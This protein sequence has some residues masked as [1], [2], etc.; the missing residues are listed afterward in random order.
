MKHLMTGIAV[1]LIWLAAAGLLL[2]QDMDSV[3]GDFQALQAL[4]SST[5]GTGIKIL[6]SESDLPAPENASY[7]YIYIIND[8]I[9]ALS[10]VR[11]RGIG[12]WVNKGGIWKDKTGWDNMTPE[13]MG[14]AVGVEVD[15]DGRVT[16]LDMQKITTEP[17]NDGLLS[18]GNGLVGTL[19][20]EIGNLKKVQFF[21]LKQN[22]FHGS[23]PDVFDGWN[24]LER[25]SI[26]GTTWEM[27]LDDRRQQHVPDHRRVM[28]GSDPYSH[29]V[30]GKAIMSTNNFKTTLPASLSGKQNL[31]LIEVAHQYVLGPLPAW[32]NMPVIQGIYISDSR[33]D[34]DYE[35]GTIPD[36]WG[37]FNSMEAFAV[38]NA[39]TYSR[40]T[41]QLPP[42]MKDWSNLYLLRISR[43][44]FSGEFPQFTNFTDLRVISISGNNFSGEFP[45]TSIFNGKNSLLN[46]FVISNCG[47][48]GELPQRIPTPTSPTRRS[49]YNINYIALQ[50]NNFSGNLP[51]WTAELSSLQIYNVSN[52]NFTGSF[53]SALLDRGNLKVAY[54]Q[55]N[56]LSGPLPDGMWDTER[57][58][59]FYLNDNNFEG[60][61][62]ESWISLFQKSD[63][64]WNDNSTYARYLFH[65]NNLI[66]R[67]PDW[68]KNVSWSGYQLYTFDGNKYTFKDILPVYDE[69]RQQFGEN[70]RVDEQK[71]FGE[72]RT[73]SMPEGSKLI[74]DLGDFHYEGNT[75]QWTKDN[76]PVEGENSPVLEIINLTTDDA[77]VYRLKVSNS[78]LLEMGVHV[79][80][81]IIFELGEEDGLNRGSQGDDD[82]SVDDGSVDDGSAGAGSF[83]EA[84]VLH[85]PEHTSEGNSLTPEFRWS[86]NGSD[87]YVFHVSRRDPTGMQIDVIVEDT[88]YTPDEILDD[89]TIHDWRVRGVKD[90]VLGEWSEIRSFT[91]GEAGLPDVAE[92]VFPGHFAQEVNPIAELVWED[93]KADSYEIRLIN[94]QTSDT[95]FTDA[96]YT[97]SY[98]PEQALS[99]TTDFV[100]QVRSIVGGVNGAWGPRW[101]FSSGL[102]DFSVGAPSP[103]S[104]D[105]GSEYVNLTPVFEWSEVGADYYV[106]S[107]STDEPSNAKS[108]TGSQNETMVIFDETTDAKYRPEDTLDP[109]TRYFWRVQAVKDGE[110]GNWSEVWE[111]TTPDEQLNVSTEQGEKPLQTSLAQN[112][113]NPFNPSTQI[114][115]TLAGAQHVSLRVYDMAGRQVA[116]LIEGVVQS[117]RHSATFSANHLASGIYLYRFISNTHQFTRKMTLVK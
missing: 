24:D 15:A 31:K 73:R 32:T 83:P 105:P 87:Y 55:G 12:E 42:A 93:V 28:T 48:S 70:F 113:P 94:K 23:V 45:W 33:G 59:W 96:S 109:E 29:A 91:T 25:W 34:P 51:S 85:G 76:I 69:L 63:G 112:Y 111:F 71:P 27:D 110:E 17:Y 36:S 77:G 61:I 2:A 84:P 35:I 18:T 99:D 3:E 67:I 30:Q 14:D 39:H 19:P 46:S 95:V 62:P 6:G 57:L 1:L 7:P 50:N 40:F 108:L 38:S 116:T 75:Y 65:G 66:G 11:L 47:F 9:Y 43:N 86:D 97:S 26:G 82:G 103:I 89:G 72:Q 58:R 8:E 92:L 68:G 74:I 4:Y 20:A 100:W 54:I 37:N 81:P 104:P 49:T 64:S 115:F 80:E 106:I 56:N 5:Q 114:E 52:N 117:G 21:N 16:T 60:E 13:T 79:S 102:Y 44:S 107:V 22:Y 90:G 10:K 98:T 88:T 101:E 53:P 78:A 41:G